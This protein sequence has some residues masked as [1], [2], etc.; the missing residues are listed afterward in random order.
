MVVEAAPLSHPNVLW[1]PFAGMQFKATA[2]KEFEVLCGGAKG[3]GK[4]D[5]I[6]AKATGQVDKPRYKALIT[7]ETGPQMLELI[8]RTHRLYPRMASKP[9]WNGSDR[10][11]TFPSGATIKFEAIASP[12]DVERIMGQ[13]WGFIGT[14]EAGNLKEE[15]T[16]DLMQAEIRSPDPAIERQWF[17]SANPG[18][19][20]SVWIK[21][22]FIDKCGLDGKR[23]YVRRLTLPNGQVAE[24]SRRFIPGTVLDNPIYANDPLYMA[25][26]YTLPEVLRNQ[27]LYGDWNA[28][29]GA[30]FTELEESVHIV[31]PFTV[32]Y[33][34]KMFGGFDWG[35]AHLWVFLYFAVNEDGDVWVTDC[36]RGQRHRIDEI[37]DRVKSRGEVQRLQYITTD[38]IAFASKPAQSKN[39]EPTIMEEMQRHGILLTAGITDRKRGLNNLR[40][41]LA[42]RGLGPQ[43]TDGEPKLRFMDTP[44][45]RWLF[46]QLQAMVTD[47]HDMEDVQKVDADT[48]TGEGGDDGYDALRVAMASRPPRGIGTFMQ[49]PV[50]AW[51]TATLNFMVEHLYR[52]GPLPGGRRAA[53]KIKSLLTPGIRG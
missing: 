10:R 29:I 14:D 15:K 2:A 20:G 36:V 39:T 4:S 23:I 28:G 12:E 47:E 7:R 46:D 35:W 50:K 49:Q 18:K 34:W 16:I 33:N 44:G 43:G 6:I 5:V 17:G 11:W 27:L 25:Q 52:D 41:Y 38:S 19:S 31:R 22:R 3:P 13:E 37:A 48:E 21:R 32:P 40:Y 30:A 24:L 9:S 45:N 8:D 51:D 53:R 1:A 26:L 42:W